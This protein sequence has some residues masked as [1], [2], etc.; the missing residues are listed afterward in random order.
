MIIDIRGMRASNFFEHDGVKFKFHSP[1]KTFP[2]NFD[3]IPK[4]FN[5]R[6]PNG[7]IKPL[8]SLKNVAVYPVYSES[9]NE[10]IGFT[11]QSSPNYELEK[12]TPFVPPNTE[13][14][15]KLPRYFVPVDTIRYDTDIDHMNSPRML[16]TFINH[17][18]NFSGQWWIG[19]IHVDAVGVSVIGKIQINNTISNCK[20]ASGMYTFQAD[21]GKPITVDMWKRAL[22]AIAEEDELNISQSLLMDAHYELFAS[23]YRGVVLNLANAIDIAINKFFIKIWTEEKG[24]PIDE[25]DRKIFVKLYKI[26]KKISDTFIPGLITEF[27]SELISRNY[28]NEFPVKFKIIDEFWRGK[29]NPVAHGA[30]I[31][32]KWEEGFIL[33]DTFDHVIDWIND[34]F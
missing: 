11:M 3:F 12:Q 14:P 16:K 32:F 4:P 34:L 8:P 10:Q 21:F 30:I 22:K 15:K 1:Y 28:K 23:N 29:R 31:T 5:Y 7:E 27:T 20:S 18:R 17:L 13:F 25:F 26:N 19:K 9:T 6:L 33:L 24:K 2:F